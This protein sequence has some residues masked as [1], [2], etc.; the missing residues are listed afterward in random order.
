VTLEAEPRFELE[1][2]TDVVPF[3][4]YAVDPAWQ[5]SRTEFHASVWIPSSGRVIRFAAERVSGGTNRQRRPLRFGARTAVASL[6]SSSAGMHGVVSPRLFGHRSAG[7]C[8]AILSPISLTPRI[9]RWTWS[10]LQ[11]RR[12]GELAWPADRAR[13][14]LP[15]LERLIRAHPE[16]A[17]N[18]IGLRMSAADDLT[19]S[20]CHGRQTFWTD[21]FFRAG[22]N[23]DDA[24]QELA[25]HFGA[26][27]HWG[28]HM[29][30]A[31]ASLRNRYPRWSAFADARRRYDPAQLFANDLTDNLTLTGA[32]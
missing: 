31:P 30:V 2:E 17:A 27:C 16:A 5:E 25:G 32:A 9:V 29:L 18:A 4:T 11:S 22:S 24:L 12:A 10:T 15:A 20:P 8:A 3:A 14:I 6:L 19:L 13:E 7:D 21:I 28:K 1:M 23:F 26:R